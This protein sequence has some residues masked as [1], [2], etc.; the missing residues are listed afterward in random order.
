M[1]PLY[2]YEL[3]DIY[4]ARVMGEAMGKAVANEIKVK[5]DKLKSSNDNKKE[6]K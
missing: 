3:R 2:T 4:I 6:S 5:R 1:E